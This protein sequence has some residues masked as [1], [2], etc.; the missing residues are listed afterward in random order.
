VL[1]STREWQPEQ[2]R[3]D[4]KPQHDCQV[5]L[6]RSP[7]WIARPTLPLVKRAVR[8]QV[9][10][11]EIGLSSAVRPWDHR[12]SQSVTER[13]KSPSPCRTGDSDSPV[14]AS[15][16]MAPDILQRCLQDL[17]SIS[18]AWPYSELSAVEN[19]LTMEAACL[20][21]IAMPSLLLYRNDNIKPF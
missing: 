13:S 7:T 20:Q 3:P 6:P 4:P 2:R 21:A 9:R 8:R 5:D 14:A 16:L 15:A 18:E 17:E 11:I 19:H 12:R 10:S 1:F